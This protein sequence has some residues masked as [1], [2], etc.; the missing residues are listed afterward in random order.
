MIAQ[1]KQK[2]GGLR[3]Y[4]DSIEGQWPE[5]FVASVVDEIVLDAEELCS[6]TCEECGAGGATANPR[7]YIQTL[8]LDCRKVMEH[9]NR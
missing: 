3:I 8:C 9:K 1:I 4:V 6:T 5:G 2:Y 7:G